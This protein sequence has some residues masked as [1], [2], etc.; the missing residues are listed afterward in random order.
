MRAFAELFKDKGEKIVR[1]IVDYH[2][3]NG[4]VSRYDKFRYIY[5]DILKQPLPQQVYEQ[6]CS[7]FSRLVFDGVV[8]SP[9]VPG[10]LEFLLEH[11]DHYR[12]H[13]ASATPHDELH[14][15]LEQR[16]IFHLFN[17]VFGA[18]I[19]KDDAVKAI[20]GKSASLP[21][22]AIFIGDALSDY[23]AACMNRVR[24]VARIHDNEA[25]FNGIPCERVRDICELEQ[26]LLT[27]VIN[28]AG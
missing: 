11:K 22:E 6:L 21:E 1:R 10:A 19:S 15:I 28:S 17:E 18:P 7:S 4:G 23:E 8:S 3:L 5:S 14:R 2:L 25:I 16:G 27:D 13:L 24:F 26:L 12:I 9:Y 20:L